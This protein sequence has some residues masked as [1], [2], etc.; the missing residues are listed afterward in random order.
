MDITRNRQCGRADF[1]QLVIF[2]KKNL[3]HSADG[4]FHPWTLTTEG[5]VIRFF[6]FKMYI[7]R[8]IQLQKAYTKMSIEIYRLVTLVAD[9]KPNSS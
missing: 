6:I 3:N 1:I 8:N 2:R 4:R 5:T 7:L 9:I